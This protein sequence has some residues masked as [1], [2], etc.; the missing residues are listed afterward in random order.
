[1]SDPY[2]LQRFVDAQSG[3]IEDVRAELAAGRKRTHWMWF[4]FPQIEGLGHSAMAQRYAIASR[5]EARAYLAHP[6]LG[7]RLVELTRLVNGVQGRGVDAIFGYPDDLK[8]H[9]SMTLF[10][11]TADDP[12]VFDEALRRYFEG[13][14]DEATLARL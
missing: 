5:D 7:A 10:A 9:S 3:V 13:R 8:F 6:V 4:V 2:D 1:M 12:A 11:R 14:A